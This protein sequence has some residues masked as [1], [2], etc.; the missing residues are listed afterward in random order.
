MLRI[1]SG[2]LGGLPLESPSG[3][4][5]KPMS[6]RI[7]G[8]LFNALGDIDG[9][10]VLDAFG[11]SGAVGLEALSRGAERV[12]ICEDDPREAKTIGRNIEKTNAASKVRLS[13]YS[14]YTA[15]RNWPEEFDLIIAD[16]PY[17]DFAKHRLEKLLIALKPNGL[18]A[19]SYPSELEVPVMAELKPIKQKTYGKAA[20][21]FYRKTDG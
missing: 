5:A 8:A 7:R 6:E 20:L 17:K 16:P 19:V 11:G 13:D 14:V 21:A 10:K 12:I 9:L 2:A 3:H 4:R 1:I 18:I 15:I